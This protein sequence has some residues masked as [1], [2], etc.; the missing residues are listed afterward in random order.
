MTMRSLAGLSV[1]MRSGW[2]VG[3][4][5]CWRAWGGVGWGKVREM[6]LRRRARRLSRERVIAAG[7]TGG[8]HVLGVL[9]K[10]TYLPPWLGATSLEKLKKTQK[11]R[12]TGSVSPHERE[13]RCE[14]P[15]AWARLTVA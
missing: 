11:K 10:P 13:R 12:A 6:R 2:V 8:S 15:G 14:R 1:G 5:G 4:V 3:A 7:D 9:P